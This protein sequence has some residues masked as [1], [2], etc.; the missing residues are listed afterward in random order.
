MKGELRHAGEQCSEIAP[1]GHPSPK[2]GD[3]AAGQALNQAAFQTRQPQLEARPHQHAEQCAGEHA[4]DDPA[5]GSGDWGAFQT[6]GLEVLPATGINADQVE[7]LAADAGELSGHRPDTAGDREVGG[8]ENSGGEQR[9]VRVPGTPEVPVPECVQHH[10][11]PHQLNPAP[12]MTPP[13][14]RSAVYRI[15]W[16]PGP[17]GTEIVRAAREL[18]SQRRKMEIMTSL[19]TPD[20]NHEMLSEHAPAGTPER[21]Q[22]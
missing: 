9:H 16:W 6:D 8:A 14:L 13:S 17:V 21:Q 2:A 10:S 3:D 11:P 5:A 20:P 7:E 1:H 18:D 22:K 4:P 19:R 12:Q 15:L